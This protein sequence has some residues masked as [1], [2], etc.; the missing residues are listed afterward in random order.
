MA[1]SFNRSSWRAKGDVVSTDMRAFNNHGDGPPRTRTEIV[2]NLPEVMREYNRVMDARRLADEQHPEKAD[3][4]A[5]AFHKA[6]EF[7]LGNDERQFR[8]N[9]SKKQR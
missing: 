9:D 4:D 7:F 5:A 1:A 2:K 3:P 6:K 8:P